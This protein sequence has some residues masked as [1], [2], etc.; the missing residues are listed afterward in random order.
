[1][2]CETNHATIYD[3]NFQK[4]IKPFAIDVIEQKEDSRD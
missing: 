4:E 2:V 1:M 3:H